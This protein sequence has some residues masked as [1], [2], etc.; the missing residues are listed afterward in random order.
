MTLRLHP[1]TSGGSSG[2][3]P[4]VLLRFAPA[5]GNPMQLG[6]IGPPYGVGLS[7]LLLGPLKVPSGSSKAGDR[8][9]YKVRGIYLNRE[10]RSTQPAI[11]FTLGLQNGS[12]PFP[13]VLNANNLATLAPGTYLYEYD[14]D[15]IITDPV[16]GFGISMGGLLRF[17]DQNDPAGLF[18]APDTG[19]A[20]TT[21]GLFDYAVDND[22][23]MAFF[24]DVNAPTSNVAGT[25]FYVYTAE[26]LRY[27]AP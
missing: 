8:L 18:C 22:V 16:Q 13:N 9:S 23:Q 26:V 7:G 20:W 3:G 25:S 6:Y 10:A 11:N 17:A 15:H 2:G 27:A 12:G 21:P 5:D 14:L 4:E 19:T 24:T 1:S